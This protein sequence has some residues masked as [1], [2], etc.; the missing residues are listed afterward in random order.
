MLLVAVSGI[1]SL[2][3]LFAIADAQGPEIDLGAGLRPQPTTGA[4]SNRK[5]DDSCGA[6]Q[7]VT[8]AISRRLRLHGR[9]RVGRPAH[10]EH[11]AP[12]P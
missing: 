3:G 11:P 5:R 10:R 7:N 9:E 4:S 2:L 6:L 1:V 12:F 8:A